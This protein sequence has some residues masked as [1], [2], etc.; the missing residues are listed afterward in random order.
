MTTRAAYAVQSSAERLA[1]I[2]A[3]IFVS[4]EPLSAKAIADV[5][6]EDRK[7]LM[8]QLDGAGAG[9]QRTKRRIAIA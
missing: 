2:E 5:L 1:V 9:I 3:L 7:L 6:R 4:E 8:K